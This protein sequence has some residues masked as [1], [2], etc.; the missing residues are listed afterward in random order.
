MTRL[1]DLVR[2]ALILLITAYATLSLWRWHWIAAILVCLPIYVVVLNL[3]GFLTLPLY[4]F[5]P[6]S[7]QGRKMLKDIE[8]RIKNGP[9]V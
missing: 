4:A 8:E 9:R 5:T 2:H 7:R 3:V 1:L 6:E